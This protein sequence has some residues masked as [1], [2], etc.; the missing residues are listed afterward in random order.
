MQSFFYI[1]EYFGITPME[2]FDFD[3]KCQK[4]TNTLLE[5]MKKLDYK[6]TNLILEVVKCI[7]KR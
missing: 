5:E 2:F 1:C 6:Q 4:E 7:N 3:D